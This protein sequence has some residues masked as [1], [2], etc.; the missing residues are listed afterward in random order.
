MKNALN[1]QMPFDLALVSKSAQE[2]KPQ[3]LL[4]FLYVKAS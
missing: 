1:F 2:A 4:R 3:R